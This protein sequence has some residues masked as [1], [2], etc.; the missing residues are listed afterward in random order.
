MVNISTDQYRKYNYE[1]LLHK[2]HSK[3]KK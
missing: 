1:P 3:Y 2:N